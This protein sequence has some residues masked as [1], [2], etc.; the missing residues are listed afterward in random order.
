MSL[1][2]YSGLTTKVRAMSGK[3]LDT[4]DYEQISSLDSVPAVLAWLKRKPSYAGILGKEN[5]NGLHRGQAE[6]LIMQSLFADFSKLYRFSDLNQRA[7]LDGYFRRY[8]ITCL[9]MIV[10]AVWGSRT[11]L[12]DI[13]DYQEIFS[14]HSSFP[15]TQAA[16]ADSMESL[17]GALKE[18]PYCCVLKSVYEG[19]RKKLFDYEFALDM[20]YFTDLWKQVGK[21]LKKQDREAVIQSVGTQIDLLN[22]QWIYRAKKYYQMDAAEIYALILPI[23]YR[24]NM[25]QMRKMAEAGGEAEMISAAKATKYGK[26]LEEEEI[27]NLEKTGTRIQESVHAALLGRN[28]YSAICLDVYLYKKEREVHKIITAMECVRYGLPADKIREYLA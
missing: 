17:I 12:A 7:F 2:R 16:S 14:R 4:Q 21:R 23:H 1:F 15:L 5:E 28:P 8:E 18:T 25:E 20:F 3:L 26:Y 13:T 24:L 19:S 27:P 10:R 6:G 22:L 11:I 9:K